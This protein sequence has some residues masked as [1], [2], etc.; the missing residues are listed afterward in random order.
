MSEKMNA[1]EKMLQDGSAFKEVDMTM[2]TGP[3][4]D[5]AQ[6]AGNSLGE[7]VDNTQE[8]KEQVQDL[9]TDFTHF[10]NHMEERI[11]SL[12]NKMKNGEVQVK[13]KV[14]KLMTPTQKRIVEL[15][16]RINKLEEV[17]LLIMETHEQLLE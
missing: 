9:H 7:R 4:L 5:E 13:S 14:G 11:N 8:Q 1:Y 17:M 16:K 2:N 3:N 10:D 15:E 12:R 6:G